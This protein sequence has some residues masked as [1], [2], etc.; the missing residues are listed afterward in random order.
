MK[1]IFFV[2]LM[3]GFCQVWAAQQE[4][5]E[6]VIHHQELEKWFGQ[7]EWKKDYEELPPALR[8]ASVPWVAVKKAAWDELTDEELLAIRD[9]Q[10]RSVYAYS[11]ATS[12]MASDSDHEYML[13]WI[14]KRSKPEHPT[15][16]WKEVFDKEDAELEE[17]LAPVGVA[18]VYQFRDWGKDHTSKASE[19][20]PALQKSIKKLEYL[21][22][23]WKIPDIA[24]MNDEI[25]AQFY[26]DH[27]FYLTKTLMY[28]KALDELVPQHS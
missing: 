10:G 3:M 15:K 19:M 11:C 24:G 4:N 22:S 8:A 27:L 23:T 28:K 17:E 12:K 14:D 1:K 6:Q 13:D 21:D 9:K 7:E 18:F 16:G 26:L 25:R 5:E 2:C 20:V